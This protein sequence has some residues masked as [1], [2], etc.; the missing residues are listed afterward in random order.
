M[1]YRVHRQWVTAQSG[2]QSV[3][4]SQTVPP[5][6]K[7]IR[8]GRRI[9]RK[10]GQHFPKVILVVGI[11]LKLFGERRARPQPRLRGESVSKPKKRFDFTG[12]HKLGN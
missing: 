3:F 6:K 8:R 9:N 10:C 1:V 11:S 2:L 4:D 7:S 12:N 5:H